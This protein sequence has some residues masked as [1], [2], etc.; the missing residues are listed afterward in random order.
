MT[1]V[2]QYLV[3]EMRDRTRLNDGYNDTGYP[4]QGLRYVPDP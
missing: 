1:G 3:S 4:A 2:K